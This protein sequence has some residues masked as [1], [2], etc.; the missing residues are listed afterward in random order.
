MRVEALSRVAAEAELRKRHAMEFARLL[1]KGDH[2]WAVAEL[3]TKHSKEY[4]TLV[5]AARDRLQTQA[6][7]DAVA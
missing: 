7:K 1:K 4:G 3:V 2:V 5:A 6:R